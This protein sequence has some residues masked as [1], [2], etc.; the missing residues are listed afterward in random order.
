MELLAMTWSANFWRKVSRISS[1]IRDFLK[2]TFKNP[3]VGPK[4]KK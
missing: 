3:R 1:G 2:Q 4:F